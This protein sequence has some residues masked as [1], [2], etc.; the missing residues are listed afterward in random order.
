[1]SV[2][3]IASGLKTANKELSVWVATGDGD[4][5]S[6]GGNHII[7]ALRR[8]LDLNILMFNNQIYGLTK[9]QYSPTSEHGKKTKS[10]PYGAVD[11]P[12][13]PLLLALGAEGTFVA[14]SIYSDAKHLQYIITRSAK[15][16][17]SSFI[18]ILQNCNIFNDNA[19]S[20]F[21][22]KETKDEHSIY[23]EH[24]K[25]LVFA[26]GTKGIRLDGFRPK[27]VELPDYSRDDLLVY[28]DKS[29]ELAFI[30]AQLDETPGFPKPFGVFL[31]IERPT[32]EDELYQQIDYA[33][34]KEGAGDLDELLNEG[35]TWEIE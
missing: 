33:I 2:S 26:G 20:M 14:R 25:P 12:F 35:N 13:N 18:D 30:M 16:K 10:S 31:D 17:G 23:I 21:T 3:K 7:H 22:D 28:D 4:C 8:N 24:G 1:M 15:H 27:I 6:I 11:H 9:G 29:K 5:L 34:A 19:F 32:Y